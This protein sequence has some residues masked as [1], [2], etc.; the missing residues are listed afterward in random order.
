[1]DT[2]RAALI[3]RAQLI[4][5]AKSMQASQSSG[6]YGQPGAVGVGVTDGPTPAAQIEAEQEPTGLMDT[7]IG[8]IG[9]G[10]KVL[11]IPRG[12]VG[13]PALAS[14]LEMLTGKNV[15]HRGSEDWDPLNPTNLKM[16]PSSAELYER[17][18]V[19]EGAKMSD[20]VGGYGE[21]EKSPWYQ[22]EKG[23]MLDFTLRGAGG[24]GTDVAIDPLTY[25][26]FGAASAGKT[27]LK[28]SAA[29]LAL[30]AAKPKP[31]MLM[32][33]GSGMARPAEILG[34]RLAP[35]INA[36]KET[37]AGRA[38]V[39][40]ATAPSRAVKNVGERM[41]NSVLLPVEHEGAKFGKKEVAE[42]IYNAGIK[43]PFGLRGKA[44]DAT[45]VL[46]EA[47]DQILKEATR[48]GAEID[49]PTA[50][51]YAEEHVA[52]MAQTAHPEQMLPGGAVDKLRQRIQ[53]HMGSAAKESEDVLRELPFTEMERGIQQ[54]PR[55]EV[56][57]Y[58]APTE[59]TGDLMQNEVIRR[60]D[61]KGKPIVNTKPLKKMPG[62]V[63]LNDAADMIDSL[64]VGMESQ[65]T[66]KLAPRIATVL[67]K[68][69]RIPGPTPIQGSKWKTSAANNAGDAAF[70]D[71]AKSAE[72]AGFEKAMAK[73]YREEVEN[74]VAR[75]LGPKA[76]A[77]VAELNAEAGK[78]I[79]T[80]K[81]QA[82]VSNHMERVKNAGSSVTGTD[83]V[84]GA[85]GTLA[86]GD[87]GGGL[88]AMG[89]KKTLDAIRL[90]YMPIGYGLKKA[91]EGSVLA[92]MIDVYTRNKLKEHLG[93]GSRSGYGKEKED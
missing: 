60:A 34:E 49:M 80:K 39:S 24:F 29:K 45:N 20:Y 64:P 27:A 1:M 70:N 2:E 52:K 82:K 93:Q 75:S 71:L 55:P 31:S 37:R 73:G 44:Q 41:Y 61:A 33:M 72:G 14:A 89:L 43:T 6:A 83:S 67:D 69:D 63:L 48:M 16:Y 77:D 47:R 74:S 11:D 56:P 36:L 28:E 5:K 46:M 50:M 42:T 65:L 76:G 18:G 23:G 81:A 30:N 85:L 12:V 17:A 66:E 68:T 53:T 62:E 90:G 26:S 19:P 51:K 15:R 57:V 22:P 10:A 87:I 21:P 78:L 32:R 91:G 84:L 35:A 8:T 54:V 13:G 59:A 25:V 92:P 9:A 4:Q 7:A 40:A 3:E 58:H 79:A 88:T 38:A 86:H